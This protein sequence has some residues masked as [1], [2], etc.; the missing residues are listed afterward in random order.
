MLHYW[1]LDAVKLNNTWLTIGS[2]DGVHRG[3]QEIV[4]RMTEAA[5]GS[6]AQSAVLT[7]HPHPAVVLG[8][9][10]GP[11][12]LTTPEYRAE[13]LGEL[14][15]DVVITH[16]FSLR[17]AGLDAET[18]MRRVKERVGLTRLWV[19]HDFALGKGREGTPDRLREIGHSL[20]Y[21]VQ[22]FAPILNGDQ[23]ISSS[24]VR[25][26]LE[27]GDIEQ[28]N[29][30]LGRPYTLTGEIVPGDNRGRSIG[31]PTANMDVWAQ[32]IIP[33][34]GVYVCQARVNGE[35]WGAVTNVGVRPT[36]EKDDVLPRVEAHLLDFDRDLYGRQ[37][38]LSFIARLRDELR[39][40]G[41][42]ALV[43]QI[44]EDIAQGREI[45]A[46]SRLPL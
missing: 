33:R 28:V 43:R 11:I 31:I 41:I 13:L 16:P 44:H 18:F 8:K 45:L 46:R 7:F 32:H 17:V 24:R 15:V 37:M 14:G 2:F 10:N 19:G 26:A 4:R 20:D 39:F 27:S 30:M 36:F 29:T 12:Y 40:P 42:D 5:H 9:R 23:P 38:R 25:A 35:T 1:N 34:A 21:Q 22:E 3:H 6:G